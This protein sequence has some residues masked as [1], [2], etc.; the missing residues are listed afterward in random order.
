LIEN[1]F[2]KLE[3][4]NRRLCYFIL[5]ISS[6]FKFDSLSESVRAVRVYALRCPWTWIVELNFTCRHP[7]YG[8]R[9][10]LILL[11]VLTDHETSVV[12]QKGVVI[13]AVIDD[14]WDEVDQK[15]IGDQ[16]SLIVATDKD[17]YYSDNVK[18]CPAP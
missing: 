7:G 16:L 14:S 4:T 10:G 15:F 13:S 9:T 2:K 11:E 8:D 3:Q 5:I 17:A 1:L 6:T 18:V 12:V